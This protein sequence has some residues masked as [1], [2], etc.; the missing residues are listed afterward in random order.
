M[1][2][3][4]CTGAETDSDSDV[5]LTEITPAH[6]DMR[7]DNGSDQSQLVRRACTKQ[8][9]QTEMPL[10]EK[11]KETIQLSREEI[12]R[13]LEDWLFKYQLQKSKEDVGGINEDQMAKEAIRF[14][15]NSL[16]IIASTAPYTIELDGDCLYNSLA[17]IR[18]PTL[19]KAENTGTGTALRRTVI[20]EAIEMIRTMTSDRL[21][22]ILLAAAPDD[23]G[24][25]LT[26]EQL[27]TMME[28][29]RDNG[30]WDGGLGDLGPQFCASF[31][32]TPLLVIWIDVRNN[33]TTG[34]FVNPGHVFNQEECVSAPSVVARL[35]NHFIPL[36]VPEEAKEALEAIYRHAQNPELQ[37]AAL[38]LPVTCKAGG[39]VM[40]KKR[41]RNGGNTVGTPQVAAD[42]DKSG[43]G[44][45]HEER[46]QQ[47]YERG[48]CTGD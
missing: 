31:T 25:L 35:N 11:S 23:Q 8:P 22:P 46:Q 40:E 18:N 7:K 2:N 30:Q 39:G 16:S 38:Q 34:Y 45:E 32:R 12:L 36:L 20:G 42:D 9:K 47:K 37:L 19:S 44:V 3:L 4:V 41:D 13:T 10:A 17:F 15:E 1:I 5:E 43:R 6:N 29:Y 21:E 26:R 28:R 27:L 14:L 33:Q 24:E 48:S